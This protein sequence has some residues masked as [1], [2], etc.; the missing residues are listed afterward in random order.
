MYIA[1]RI[2]TYFTGKFV[3]KDY[4]GNS[5][6][7]SIFK[8][9]GKEKRWVIFSGMVEGSKI[10]PKWYRWIHYISDKLPIEEINEQHFWQQPYAPNH[11]GTDKAYYPIENKFRNN[12]QLNYKSW[13]PNEIENTK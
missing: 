5:Y 11:T 2:L 8:R 3:G 7:R 9:A 12:N 4:F 6:Y 1:T 13:N 10:P